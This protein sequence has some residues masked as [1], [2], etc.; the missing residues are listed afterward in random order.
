MELDRSGCLSAETATSV[1][2]TAPASGAGT[3]TIT[4]TSTADTTTTATLTVTLTSLPVITTTSLPNVVV[5][6]AYS[7]TI[8]AAGGAGTLTFTLSAGTLPAGL[9][10]SSA[11]AITGTP[12][13]VGKA[14]FTVKVTDASSVSAQ[15]ATQALSITVNQAPTIT[16]ANIVTAVVGTASTFTATATGIPTPSLTETGALPNGV[17]FTD[18]GNGTGTLGGT[19]AAGTGKT[20]AITFTASNGVGSAASQSFT[21]TV[22]EGPRHHQPQHYRDYRGHVRVVYSD[23][24]WL[25]GSS[26]DGDRCAA[27]RSDL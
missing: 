2:Y 7:Q 11:G 1:N 8:A 21:L 13:S 6:T 10:L 3:A 19:P 17:T 5:G 4:A 23:D 15:S 16:S 18:N 26:F 14:N 24:D 27:E 22:D 9:S 12:T 20:Y 25:S